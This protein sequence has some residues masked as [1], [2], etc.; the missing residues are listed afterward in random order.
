ME[1]ALLLYWREGNSDCNFFP[2]LNRELESWLSDNDPYIN[3]EN[4]KKYYNNLDN[5]EFV[6]FKNKCH[7]NKESWVLEL[8]EIL[9]YISR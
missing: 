3:L 2:Y 6:E 9:E 7:F 4:S 1:K 5:I 8:E